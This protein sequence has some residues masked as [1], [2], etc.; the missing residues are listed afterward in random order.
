[1]ATKKGGYKGSGTSRMRWNGRRWVPAP[2]R[3][4][5][6]AKPRSTRTR[7]QNRRSSTGA[8][9]KAAASTTPKKTSSATAP[10]KT[11]LKTIPAKDRPKDMQAGKV[12]GDAGQPPAP[13]LPPRPQNTPARVP[14]KPTRAPQKK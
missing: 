2:E 13:T 7:T 9:V 10:T 6:P 14:A 3:V 5:T 12:Y 4:V 11:P 8:A 1:M